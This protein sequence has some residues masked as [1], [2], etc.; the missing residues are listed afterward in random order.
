MVSFCSVLCFCEASVRKREQSTTTDYLDRGFFASTRISITVI[1]KV[2]FYWGN[3][4][5]IHVYM[6]LLSKKIPLK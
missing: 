3:P 1:K 6:L 2:D 4:H 5:L